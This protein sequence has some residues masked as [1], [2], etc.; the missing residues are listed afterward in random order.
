MPH[1][2]KYPGILSK[3]ILVKKN[4]RVEESFT[5]YLWNQGSMPNVGLPLQV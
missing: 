3:G 4:D 5:L 1:G 2:L